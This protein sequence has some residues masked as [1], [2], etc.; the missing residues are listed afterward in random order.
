MSQKS[1]ILKELAASSHRLSNSPFGKYVMASLK[2]ESFKQQ[3]SKWEEKQKS[4][5]KTAEL[6]S[7]IIGDSKVDKKEDLKKSVKPK[8]VKEEVVVKNGKDELDESENVLKI[9]VC[10]S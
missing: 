10:F 8:S 5:K 2:V 1:D 7:D 6:F 9:D 3:G 4:S